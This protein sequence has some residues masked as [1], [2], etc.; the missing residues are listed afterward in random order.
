MKLFK[1]GDKASVL[2]LILA[3][4]VPLVGV[5]FFD[6]DVFSVVLLYWM[7]NLVLGFYTLLKIILLPAENVRNQLDKVLTIPFFC[8][9]YGMFCFGHGVFIFAI[10]TDFGIEGPR[11]GPADTLF[12]RMLGLIIPVLALGVSHGISF[13]QNYLL[14]KEYNEMNLGD[15]MKA[16]YARIVILHVALIAAGFFIVLLGSP[17][18][19]L[20]ILIGMKT[21]M[22]VWLHNREHVRLQKE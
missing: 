7:E 20:V 10:F 3:N 15:L 5:F 8:V 12:G 4:L 1:A 17:I 13:V 6:W 19:L 16:P 2:A 14:G 18:P 21:G 9:H 22:D 11:N